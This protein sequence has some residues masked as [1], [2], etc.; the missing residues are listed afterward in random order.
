MALPGNYTTSVGLCKPAPLRVFL[1]LPL[2]EQAPG[3]CYNRSDNHRFR[4]FS[5]RVKLFEDKAY[6][7][8]LGRLALPMALYCT[9]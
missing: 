1:Y 5:M 2:I 8:K 7:Q 6:Y 9:A 3:I 4:G